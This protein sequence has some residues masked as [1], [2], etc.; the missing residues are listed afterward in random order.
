M[1]ITTKI[2]KSYTWLR[3]AM[4]K[5][6]G[7]SHLRWIISIYKNIIMYLKQIKMMSLFIKTSY[8]LN[9]KKCYHIG[10]LQCK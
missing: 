9:G 7:K 2:D 5:G 10:L 8:R 3:V 6:V 4:T 1:A